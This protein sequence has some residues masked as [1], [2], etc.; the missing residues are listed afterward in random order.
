M[1]RCEYKSKFPMWSSLILGD[2]GAQYFPV[3]MKDPY[4]TFYDTSLAAG[5]W[6]PWYTLMRVEV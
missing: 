1:A 2:G 6:V 5:V 3:V 4:S